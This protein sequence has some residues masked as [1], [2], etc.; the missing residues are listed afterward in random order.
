MP[1]S[2]MR[3]RPS[4]SNIQVGADGRIRILD[5]GIAKTVTVARSLTVHEFGSPNY[6]SPERLN[7]S[8]VDTDAD[9]W[10]LGVT[11]YEMVAGS[12]PYQAE[13]TQRLEHLI[14]SKR[15]P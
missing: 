4:P 10:A 6:C 1:K 12:P 15:P 7:R 8:E 13:D 14:Q 9:L 5:F 2:R 3:M 11:L